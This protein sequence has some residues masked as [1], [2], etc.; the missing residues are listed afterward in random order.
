MSLDVCVYDILS[1]ECMVYKFCDYFVTH[2]IYPCSSFIIN[3][4][5]ISKGRKDNS[6]FQLIYEFYLPLGYFTIIF[7]NRRISF[8]FGSWSFQV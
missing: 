2:F 3:T 6:R 5:L 1:D 4:I 7:P 8:A